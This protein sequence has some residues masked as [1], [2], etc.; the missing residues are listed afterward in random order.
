M[1]K[2]SEAL[3]AHQTGSR[4]YKT[5]FNH[6]NIE[7]GYKTLAE[8]QIEYS[9]SCTLQA[10]FYAN[11]LASC[12][13]LTRCAVKV[14]RAILEEVFGEFRKDFY[15]LDAAL[16]YNDTEKAKELLDKITQNMYNY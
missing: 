8:Y 9:M 10:K 14:K 5:S 13:D 7:G 11:H 3:E 12:E 15:E 4:G 1:S 16:Y 6:M 2:L